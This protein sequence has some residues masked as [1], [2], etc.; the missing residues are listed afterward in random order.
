MKDFL[1]PH[2]G[3]LVLN[4]LNLDFDTAIWQFGAIISPKYMV[5]HIQ[6]KSPGLSANRKLDLILQI[7]QINDTLYKFSV[8]R[9]QK[10][11]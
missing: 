7:E 5:N 2:F 8:E 10:F 6:K 3:D 1:Q 11:I 9:L 4:Q